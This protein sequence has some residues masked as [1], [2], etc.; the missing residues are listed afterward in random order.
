[1]IPMTGMALGTLSPDRVQNASGLFNLTRN[2]GGALGLAIINS[3]LD[4]GRD[5]HR[6]ELASSMSAGHGDVQGWIDQTAAALAAQG[7]PNPHNGALALLANMV[8][9]EATVMAFNN[10]FLMM[11]VTF[12][13]LLPPSRARQG[14]PR[15]RG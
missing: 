14:P 1:M 4:Q 5:L 15:I 2:L 7:A 10:V 9:R 11:A 8:E 6:T 12:A 3:L 13:L